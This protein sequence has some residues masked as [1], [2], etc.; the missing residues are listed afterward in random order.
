MD[1]VKT[2]AAASTY[3][4]EV[5]GGKRFEFGKNWARFLLGLNDDRIA[6]AEGSLCRMLG[7]T[8]LTGKTFVDVGSGSGLFS[9]AARRLGAKVRSF[10]FDPR[11][12]ACTAELRRRYFPGDQAWTVDEASALDGA[13]I[14][15]LG[16]FDIV[17]SWGV[18]HHTGKM[19]AA[20]DNVCRLVGPGGQL[21]IAIYNDQ[22][23]RSRRWL[24]AKR[25]Y[26]RLPGPLKT[27]WAVLAIL[28]TEFKAAVSALINRR[29]VQYLHS[30]VRVDPSRGMSRWR[31]VI[32]W[33]GGY[34]YEYAAPDEI[35]EFYRERGLS[36]S[37]L[38]CKTAGSGCVE[39]VFVRTDLPHQPLVTR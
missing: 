21:F 11:S 6:A 2:S 27:P 17:Y 3:S 10:D 12:V 25:L 37:E 19:W 14:N 13:Y 24:I 32:D 4:A 18:L 36:L 26:N 31:D 7:L 16:R 34:P 8:T 20:L 15:S 23:S 38:K 30:W 39:Y 33:V 35:F 22:G 29:L 9:L 1:R 28:P 5:E